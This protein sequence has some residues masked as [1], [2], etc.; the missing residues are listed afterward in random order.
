MINLLKYLNKK[1]INQTFK[2]A[3]FAINFFLKIRCLNQSFEQAQIYK[4][5]FTE[6]NWIN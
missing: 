1:E 2:V 4:S 6:R 5:K 3:Y